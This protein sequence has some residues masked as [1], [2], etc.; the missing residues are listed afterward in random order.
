MADKS[1]SSNYSKFGVRPRI[2]SPLSDPGV[3]E[4]FRFEGVGRF[5]R[6]FDRSRAGLGPSVRKKEMLHRFFEEL[7]EAKLRSDI[8][9]GYDI[10]IVPYPLGFDLKG[11]GILSDRVGRLYSA[12]PDSGNVAEL[13]YENG[14][15]R[16]MRDWRALVES[17]N[18]DEYDRIRFFYNR[19]KAITE[20][21]VLVAGTIGFGLWD[22]LW[23]AFDFKTAVRMLSGDPDFAALV[24]RHWKSF[25][26]GAV[27]AMLDAGIKMIFFRENARG[28]SLSSEVSAR[29]D[30]FLRASFDELS[31]VVHT[32]GGTLF[33]DCD[34]DEMIETE[35]PIR[36]GFDGVGPLLFRDM[37]DLLSA[38]KVVNENLVLIGTSL[39]PFLPGAS[40]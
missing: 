28:F 23:M 3:P 18:P 2:L 5:L 34:A 1:K 16:T 24:F 27:S 12:T 14:S 13:R 30:P 9:M 17:Q 22:A 6:I 37:E 11:W 15:C 25:H 19:I 20:K 10:S 26:I 38:R 7:A 40:N 39:C 35:Y 29:L 8:D 36:W 21:G 4:S 33:F 31:H 32:R